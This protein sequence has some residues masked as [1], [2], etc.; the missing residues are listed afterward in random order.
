VA[1]AA[2]VLSDSLLSMSLCIQTMRLILFYMEFQYRNIAKKCANCSREKN[3][4][5]KIKK[6]VNAKELRMNGPL[7]TSK[8]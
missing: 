7:L 3:K 5:L 4:H 8:L 2:I 6:G 1:R